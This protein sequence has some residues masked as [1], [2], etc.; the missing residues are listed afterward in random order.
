[1][2]AP[3]P[4]LLGGCGQ[5]LNWGNPAWPDPGWE[6]TG[7][8][9]LPLQGSPPKNL[10]A[11]T[12]SS[13]R[14]IWSSFLYPSGP[15]SDACIQ[16][17]LAFPGCPHRHLSRHTQGWT[18]NTPGAYPAMVPPPGICPNPLQSLRPVERRPAPPSSC[19]SPL[20]WTPLQVKPPKGLQKLQPAH[21]SLQRAG[22]GAPPLHS[23]GGGSGPSCS[24]SPQAVIASPPW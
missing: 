21:R 22:R 5:T 1:M 24:L 9:F 2:A 10:R 8:P 20:S 17:Q 18:H 7:T 13:P 4:P 11:S 14:P 19:H 15:P 3:H 16:V 23:G 12:G 6:E